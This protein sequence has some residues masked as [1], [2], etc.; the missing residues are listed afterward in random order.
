MLLRSAY[1]S[2]L[3]FSALSLPMGA[4]TASTAKNTAVPLAGVRY[5][6]WTEELMQ[7][8][9]PE[10][11][12]SMIS[13]EVDNRG[14]APV[15]DAMLADKQG[16]N[17]VHY[18]NTDAQLETDRKAG[19]TVYK[20][21]MQLDEPDALVKG[22]Q[23]M[24]RFNTE[25]GVPVVWQF[26]L[27]TDLTEQGGGIS[28][29]PSAVPEVHYRTVGALAGEGTAIQI[30]GVTSKADVWKEIAQPPYFVPYR[31]A[32]ATDIH[33][34]TFMPGETVWKQGAREMTDEN[35]TTVSLARE[36]TQFSIT[37]PARGTTA[38]YQLADGSGIARVSFG[39]VKAK[40][41]QTVSLVFTPPVAPGIKSTFS[42]VVGS[43]DKIVTGTVAT[44]AGSGNSIDESWS[45][46][47]STPQR[48]EPPVV[49]AQVSVLP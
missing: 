49:K 20:V 12:Y 38:A 24:L 21:A 30:G 31:G 23:Y 32:V 5:R 19:L 35:G 1:A 46:A 15:Y 41:N 14:K 34:L 11:P 7:F 33:I 3:L 28:P 4:Q 29:V 17:I 37:D 42:M 27:G 22:A 13:I 36:A 18:V 48:T 8:I 43:K 47:S 44:A 25:K 39:P 9:G 26:I 45:L 2:M 6:Y 10:L 40:R 16:K